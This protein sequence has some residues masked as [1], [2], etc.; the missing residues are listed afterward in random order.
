VFYDSV[1]AGSTTS[2]RALFTALSELLNGLAYFSKKG[3]EP[4][5]EFVIPVKR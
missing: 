2:D 1:A 3:V 5:V 4:S